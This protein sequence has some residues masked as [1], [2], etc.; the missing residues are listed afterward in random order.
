MAGK[1]WRQKE[2]LTVDSNQ[3]NRN[4][5]GNRRGEIRKLSKYRWSMLGK[6]IGYKRA[7]KQKNV[8][9]ILLC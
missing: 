2:A 3:R 4:M 8:Y 7:E 9:N 6:L 1:N 5:K